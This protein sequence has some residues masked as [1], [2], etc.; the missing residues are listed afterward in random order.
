MGFTIPN[1]TDALA[2]KAVGDQAEPDS[3]DFQILG[4]TTSALVYDPTTYPTNGFVEQSS[5][6]GQSV[7]VGAYKVLIK[8]VY[9]T[10]GTTSTVALV[11]GGANPRFDLIVVPLATPAVPVVRQGVESSDNPVFP[12]LVDDDVVLAAVYR[13]AGTITSYATNERIV[14]KRQFILS[15]TTWLKTAAPTVS[16]GVNG[17]LWVDTTA[18][19]NGQSMLWFKRSGTWENLAE[20]IATSSTNTANAVVQRDASGNFSAGTITANLTGTAS[21]A[22]WTGITGRP[23]VGNVTVGTA[24]TPSGGAAG[25]IYI[26]VA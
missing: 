21:A 3:V 25:D 20:Y 11:E 7:K 1:Y 10:K 17:D 9:Y 19:A 4:S 13:P 18:V 26:Q 5:T 15:N 14:D 24:A 23:T 2:T 8:G 12:V 16:D 22:P 6:V